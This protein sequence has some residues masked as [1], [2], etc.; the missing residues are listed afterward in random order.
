MINGVEVPL[1]GTMRAGVFGVPVD[2]VSLRAEDAPPGVTVLPDFGP[3]APG[4]ISIPRSEV[5]DA[6]EWN[7]YA[8]VDED[9]CWVANIRDG[10]LFVSTVVSATAAKNPEWEGDRYNGWGRWIDPEGVELKAESR[11]LAGGGSS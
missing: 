8:W 4:I 1:V 10:K 5:A 7:W 6:V 11:P 9:W 2:S 3:S